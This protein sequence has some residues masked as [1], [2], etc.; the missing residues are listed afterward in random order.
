MIHYVATRYWL[1]VMDWFLV[2]WAP[3]LEATIQRL[4]YPEL[5]RKR[6]LPRG[7]WI[8]ADV[9]RLSPAE[10][11]RAAQIWNALAEAGK[12]VR[13]LNHPVR[14][15]R[16]YELLRMLH[17]TGVNAFDVMRLDEMRRPKRYPVFVR[18][19]R[20][21][22]GDESALL[23]GP[24]ELEAE[25]DRRVR[26]G[27][28]LDG[29]IAVEFCGEADARG[30]YRKYS[31][32]RIGDAIVPR[33]VLFSRE[34]LI[35]GHDVL[36]PEV[37]AEEFAY[38]RDNPHEGELRE[39]FERARI[40]YGRVDY[41][42]VGGRIQV[43]EINTAPVIGD[44]GPEACDALRQ[45]VLGLVAARLAEAF[46]ALDPGGEGAPISAPRARPSL[47]HTRLRYGLERLLRAVGLRRFEPRIVLWVLD[48]RD[49]WR[50]RRG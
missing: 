23:A 34:W 15:M 26:A 42:V 22:G 38:I 28:S 25:I 1:S 5:C 47:D 40:D 10:Q 31:A 16:R 6:E 35:K 43:Y 9:E 11:A 3:E 24:E 8:F 13:L 18:R 32:F 30:L 49:A 44:F 33:H 2:E 45:P 39:V 21:H 41:S 20:D 27:Q 14:S 17:E 7:A 19:E 36:D 48:R 46:A 37:A 50:A 12:G 4:A 29:R